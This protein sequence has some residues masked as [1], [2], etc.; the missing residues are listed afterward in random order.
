MSGASD[1][2][3]KAIQRDGK[4]P[5]RKTWDWQQAKDGVSG[6]R[7]KAVELPTLEAQ[8]PIKHRGRPPDATSLA[9]I[10]LESL[11][12]SCVDGGPSVACST[13]GGTTVGQSTLS[14]S[15]S[16][17]GLSLPSSLLG[18]PAAAGVE[19]S[20]GKP[21]TRAQKLY[22]LL[23]KA[24]RK[25]NEAKN[26]EEYAEW[27]LEAEQAAEA[28]A[29]D[30]RLADRDGPDVGGCSKD[31]SEGGEEQAGRMH[32]YDGAMRVE[33]EVVVLRA[34]GADQK[35]DTPRSRL[36]TATPG[37]DDLST[38]S[39]SS[40]EE[41]IDMAELKE[42]KEEFQDSE[43]EEDDEDGL[44]EGLKKREGQK[45]NSDKRLAQILGKTAFFVPDVERYSLAPSLLPPPPPYGDCL[46]GSQKRLKL[47]PRL[48]LEISR[49][50]YPD[51]IPY[52]DEPAPYSPT[53]EN[54]AT[55]EAKMS[56]VEFYRGASSTLPRWS[57]Q[58]PIR[59]NVGGPGEEDAFGTMLDKELRSSRAWRQYVCRQR[60]MAKQQQSTSAYSTASKLTSTPPGARRGN[61]TTLSV[62]SAVRNGA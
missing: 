27:A 60:R 33:V 40:A 58:R 29:R 11:Q 2:F 37:G 44:P 62:A 32:A 4:P 21:A 41:R 42:L 51:E 55:L 47:K 22:E 14:T 31:G 61:S 1:A 49:G 9:A 19:V 8:R 48:P 38:Q 12:S 18:A 50:R 57:K 36:S 52:A 34:P 46:G 10:Q 17:P 6:F 39:V 25:R 13:T 59:N 15:V 26:K 54:R 5:A 20:P 7:I 43:E 23:L 45:I 16:A 53:D 35:D 3:L 30:H 56:T 28:K 24:E